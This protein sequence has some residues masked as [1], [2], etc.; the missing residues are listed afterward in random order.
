[1]TRLSETTVTGIKRNGRENENREIGK[2][3][4]KII[5][6]GK[7]REKKEKRKHLAR[8]WLMASF[9]TQHVPVGG[10]ASNTS[11]ILPA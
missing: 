4:R 9:F 10:Q 5:R 3:A 1:M 6:K 11:I 7:K 2:L 8:H